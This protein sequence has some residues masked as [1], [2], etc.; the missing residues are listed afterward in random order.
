MKEFVKFFDEFRKKNKIGIF[1][2]L[3]KEVEVVV[4]KLKSVYEMVE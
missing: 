4:K 2:V 1:E 3:G